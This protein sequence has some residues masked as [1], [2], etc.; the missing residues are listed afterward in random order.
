MELLGVINLNFRIIVFASMM[1][2]ITASMSADVSGGLTADRLR[3][4]ALVDPL[5]ATSAAPTLSWIGVGEGENLR[6]TAYQVMVSSSYA[7]A[8]AGEA[9]LWDSGRVESADSLNIQY[10]GKTLEPAQRVYW[11]VRLWDQGSEPGWGQVGEPGGWSEIAVFGAP[12]PNE[13]WTDEMWIGLDDLPDGPADAEPQLANASWIVHTK[14]FENSRPGPITLGRVFNLPPDAEVAKAYAWI[15]ADDRYELAVNGQIQQGG[16]NWRQAERVD[17]TNDLKAGRNFLR[18]RVTNDSQGPVGL[19]MNLRIELADGRTVDVPTDDQWTVGSSDDRRWLHASRNERQALAVSGRKNSPVW[20]DEITAPPY[21]TLEPARY[22]RTS[23][24]APQ[25]IEQ[26]TL[27]LVGLGFADAYVN[28]ELVTTYFISDWTHYETRVY[29]YAFDVTEQIVQ[30]DNALGIVLSDGWFSG[31]IGWSGRDNHYG[32]LPR[33]A[34]QLVIER[35]DGSRQIVKSDASWRGS[36]GP[37]RSADTLMGETYD[38]TITRTD[39]FS[40]PG[41]DDS[42]WA[43]VS[44]GS[45]EV[46]PVVEPNPGV[47]IDAFHEFE[48]QRITEPTPGAYVLDMGRNFAGVVRLQVEGEPGQ[49]ITLRFGERLNPDGTLYTANLRNARATDVY[50]CRGDGVETWQPRFTFHGFQYVEVT[51]LKERPTRDTITGVAIGSLTPRIGDFESSSDMLNQLASNIYW[52][53]RSNFISIPTDCPQ[54]DERLG[55][56]GDAQVYIRTAGLWC[57]VQAFF[58]KWLIDLNDATSPDGNPPKVAPERLNNQDGGPAW[59][60]AATI[61]PWAIYKMYDDLALLERQ[62]PAMKAYVDFTTR[63]S[64]PDRLPPSEFH[65]YGDWLD[66]QDPTPKEV[67]YMAYWAQSTRL[68]AQTAELLGQQDD[69]ERYT[70][71]L[72]EIIAAFNREFVD[73][74]GRVRGNSQTAYVLALQYGM[75]S[76]KRYE[77]AAEHLINHIKSRNGHLATGFIGTKDLMLVLAKIGRNDVAYR[78]AMNE[79]YPSWGFSIRHGATSIWER[80]DGWTPE[81][82]FQNVG[83]NSFAHYAFGAVYQWMVEQIGGIQIVEPGYKKFRIAPVPGGGLTYAKVKVDSVRGTIESDWEI[84]NNKIRMRVVIP[85]NSSCTVVVP[86]PAPESISIVGRSGDAA[87]ILEQNQASLELGSGTYEIEAVY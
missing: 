16:G 30:G 25:D 74:D 64:T 68:V 6:Q 39:G 61:C 82:G 87:T 32:A 8:E 78:L 38:N 34:L 77:Q 83:M 37:V 57:D 23:F 67:I 26:A 51:G 3:A 71:L 86:T 18:I 42:S 11:R 47:K 73:S 27:Y 5:Q 13:A 84:K 65:A 35:A 55:W 53:Q 1:I 12:L 2:L 22:L 36:T 7:L 58:D 20:R 69:A 14:D 9:D 72:E 33:A 50:I 75:V 21:L 44:T 62:Y 54:R 24:E 80:W 43:N 45:K 48:P 56:T 28:G 19:L 85:P 17:V 40:E 31:F 79:D 76:G 52:T 46:N 15:A 41:F 29:S 81:N 59:A 70:K 63:R 49:R 60:D 66:V 10:A 4:D